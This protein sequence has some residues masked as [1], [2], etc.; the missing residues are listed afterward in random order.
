MISAWYSP[1][2][3]VNDGSLPENTY[4]LL[5]VN[6]TMDN[7]DVTILQMCVNWSCRCL[8]LAG[9]FVA[10]DK[11]RQEKCPHSGQSGWSPA[12]FPSWIMLSS[13]WRFQWIACKRQAVCS[14][15]LRWRHFH[16]LSSF[17]E[18]NS[19]KVTPYSQAQLFN[20]LYLWCLDLPQAVHTYAWWWMGPNRNQHTHGVIILPQTRPDFIF[21]AQMQ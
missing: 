10:K 19:S 12:N 17:S 6:F 11:T 13:L 14:V 2:T 9:W 3:E 1:I 16:S 4:W 8:V 5:A 21:P 15:W 20:N 18:L 7:A